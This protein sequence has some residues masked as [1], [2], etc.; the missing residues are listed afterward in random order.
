MSASTP[1][2]AIF[3]LSLV[4]SPEY[5]RVM[6]AFVGVDRGLITFAVAATAEGIE[7]G[8]F[9][10]PK[11]LKRRLRRLRRRSRVLSRASRGSKN[12]VKA[13]HLLAREH[14]RIANVRRNFLHEVS[15]QPPPCPRY[16]RRCLGGIRPP[17]ELQSGLAWSGTGGL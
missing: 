13:A 8:R 14:A 12:W 3:T 6:G 7:V 11:P 17:T 15:S 9:H 2:P 5:L 4:T 1:K 16:R 10:S